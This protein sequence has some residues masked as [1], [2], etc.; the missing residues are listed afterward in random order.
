MENALKYIKDLHQVFESYCRNQSCIQA[1]NSK[2]NPLEIY[3]ILS[4]EEKKSLS[5]DEEKLIIGSFMIEKINGHMNNLN[6]ICNI[7]MKNNCSHGVVLNEWERCGKN[8]FLFLQ[9]RFGDTVINWGQGLDNADILEKINKGER[10]CMACIPEC[11]SVPISS[12]P[13]PFFDRPVYNRPQPGLSIHNTKGNRVSNS[14]GADKIRSL[15][16]LE[17]LFR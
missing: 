11:P 3:N 4:E 15:S 13:P 9:T 1:W 12:N 14:N 8:I 16:E 17:R 5:I 6:V 2:K 7:A 10:P